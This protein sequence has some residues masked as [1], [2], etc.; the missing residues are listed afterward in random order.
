MTF[1]YTHKIATQL[2]T[3]INEVVIERY[4]NRCWCRKRKIWN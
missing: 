2:K 3:D 4:E 1:H